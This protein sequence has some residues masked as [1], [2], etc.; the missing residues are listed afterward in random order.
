M[1]AYISGLVALTDTDG[2]ITIGATTYDGRLYYSGNPAP[3]GH[4]TEG[5]A[6]ALLIEPL[7]ASGN[8]DSTGKIV[9]LGDGMSN[10][11]IVF[12]DMRRKASSRAENV[13]LVTGAQVGH[14][15]EYVANNLAAHYTGVTTALTAKGVTAAQVQCIWL[16]TAIADPPADEND[17]IDTLH[18]YLET[19]I[20][21]IKTRFPNCQIVALQ[22]REYGGWGS[23][24]SPEPGA[25]YSALAV[26]RIIDGQVQA[27]N[28]NVAYAST[29]FLFWDLDLYTWANGLGSDGV[30]G[31]TPGRA[32]GLEYLESDFDDGTHTSDAGADKISDMMIHMFESSPYTTPWWYPSAESTTLT[33]KKNLTAVSTLSTDSYTATAG[34]AKYA[35]IAHRCASAAVPNEP[36]AAGG[37]TAWATAVTKIYATAGAERARVSILSSVGNGVADTLDV[38][39]GGQNQSVQMIVV[40]EIAGIYTGGVSAALGVVQ[41]KSAAV[42]AGTEVSVAMDA[43]T[44]EIFMLSVVANTISSLVAPDWT[45]IFDEDS[46]GSPTLGLE[47]QAFSGYD[48]L[49]RGVKSGAS[50]FNAAILALGLRAPPPPQLLAVTVTGPGEVTSSPAGIDCPD[51]VC[52]FDFPEG[53]VVTLTAVADAGYAFHGWTG[54]YDSVSGLTATVTMS[55]AKE[56]GALFGLAI[57]NPEGAAYVARADN[58]VFVARAD[59]WI[60]GGLEA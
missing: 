29:P 51:V 25:Y 3:A 46:G 53:T 30:V 24:T 34:R 35:I 49:A 45:E 22:T 9:V 33:V 1:P 43:E 7:D 12:E 56:I 42:D 40:L 31:G 15:A 41:A 32:D 39:W 50:T 26:W 19:I 28:A 5:D 36:T 52:D 48:S 20:V 38:D 2:P 59:N 60:V 8:P 6:R 14:D 37:G 23:V 54:D 58:A 18:G 4:D 13:V 10:A 11:R 16:Y 47:I 27:S 55:A 17:A 21:D 57:G 44:A